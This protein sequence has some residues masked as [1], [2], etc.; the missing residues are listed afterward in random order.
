MCDCMCISLCESL[1]MCLR[2]VCSHVVFLK[3]IVG[4]GAYT[5]AYAYTNACAYTYTKSCACTD[6]EIQTHAQTHTRRHRHTHTHTH[7][8][9]HTQRE[10]TVCVVWLCVCVCVCVCV[11]CT[12]L[13]A[14]KLHCQYYS[15]QRTRITRSGNVQNVLASTC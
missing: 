3:A 5:C 4:S 7:T 9:I 15:F 6:I 12:S 1:Y 2:C 10:N 8:Q 13:N 11:T 14:S